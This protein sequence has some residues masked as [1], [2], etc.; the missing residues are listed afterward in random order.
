MWNITSEMHR[1][2]QLRDRCGVAFG[3][4]LVVLTIM[5]ILDLQIGLRLSTQ[6]LN[7]VPLEEKSIGEKEDKQ[8]QNEETTNTKMFD[9]IE[10]LRNRFDFGY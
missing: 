2:T 6:Y 3:V 10:A 1:P 7:G 8:E 9:V 5:L 4:L